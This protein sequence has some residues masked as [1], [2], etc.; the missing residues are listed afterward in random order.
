MAQA[1]ETVNVSQNLGKMF[2]F[3][4]KWL[5][6]SEIVFGEIQFSR[7]SVTHRK[8][9]PL[10]ISRKVLVHQTPINLCC[11]YETPRSEPNDVRNCRETA[12]PEKETKIL[13]KGARSDR[14]SPGS[15][16]AQY[17][18]FQTRFSSFLWYT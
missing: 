6:F 12:V 9:Q 8:K 13:E 7:K 15:K 11:Y 3:A 5:Y 17:Q 14:G 2:P 4:Q 1:L 10:T 16:K 18:T